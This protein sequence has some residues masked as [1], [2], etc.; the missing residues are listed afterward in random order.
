MLWVALGKQALEIGCERRLLEACI[1][2][3]QA[4]LVAQLVHEVLDE[5]AAAQS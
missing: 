1:E 5:D 2:A 4:H 3:L